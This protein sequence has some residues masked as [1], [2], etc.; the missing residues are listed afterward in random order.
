[1]S[2]DTLL[3]EVYLVKFILT[4][5]LGTPVICAKLTLLLVNVNIYES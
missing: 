3:S 1:M 4:Q 2:G 5:L